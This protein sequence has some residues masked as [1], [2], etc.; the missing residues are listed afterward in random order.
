MF[1]HLTLATRDVAGT[2]EFLTKAMPWKAL[3][4]PANIEVDAAWLEIAPGQQ[5]HVLGIEDF[6]ISTCE[7]EYG[8]HIAFFH[9]RQDWEPLKARLAALDTE[10]IPPL[11]ETPFP[12]FFFRDPNGYLFEVIEQESFVEERAESS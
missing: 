8:R 5:I 7:R 11:R 4:M 10:V 6:E 12:R 2:V 3:E 9:P 1:A